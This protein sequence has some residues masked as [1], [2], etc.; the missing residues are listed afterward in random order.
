VPTQGDS[1]NFERKDKNGTWVSEH[2]KENISNIL[3]R[4]KLVHMNS[5]SRTGAIGQ[6][7]STIKSRPSQ[8]IIHGS[9]IH[10]QSQLENSV[11][12]IKNQTLSGSASTSVLRT[13]HSIIN[14][15]NNKENLKKSSKYPTVSK[16]TKKQGSKEKKSLHTKTLSIVKDM[17]TMDKSRQNQDLKFKISGKRDLSS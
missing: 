17:V 14:I 12:K 16:I 6:S 1:H 10:A 7:F 13:N 15:R 8:G 5:E 11:S 9:S 4:S 3:A 2:N